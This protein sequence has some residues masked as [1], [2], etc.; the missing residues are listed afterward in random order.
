M[1]TVAVIAD[2]TPLYALVDSDDQY[3]Q[4]SQSQLRYLGNSNVMVAVPIPVLLEPHTLV[5]QR[6]G[7]QIAQRWPQETVDSAFTPNA[8]TEDVRNAATIV[9]RYSDQPITLADAIVAA[10]S[11][12]LRLPV[13]TYDHHFDIMQVEVWR[14]AA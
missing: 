12:R 9:Q 14:G 4:R 1:S 13:W 6:L 5:L 10:M 11:Q 2:S 3:A 8:S 7:I